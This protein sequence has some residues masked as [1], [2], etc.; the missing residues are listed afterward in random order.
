MEG[1]W[2]EGGRYRHP[3]LQEP[4]FFSPL[5]MRQ[6]HLLPCG[7]KAS[8]SKKSGRRWLRGIETEDF[9]FFWGILGSNPPPPQVLHVCC[10][11][12][13]RYRRGQFSLEAAWRMIFFLEKELV[14]NGLRPIPFFGQRNWNR[15]HMRK[16]HSLMQ[17]RDGPAKVQPGTRWKF[18]LQ[19]W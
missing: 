14:R 6:S 3:F 1:W 9:P 4:S 11:Y 19:I 10:M 8:R 17:I 13:V 2:G 18:L 15:I 12:N 16:V 5:F 7:I